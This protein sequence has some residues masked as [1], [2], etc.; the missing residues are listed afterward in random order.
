M[1][2]IS[3]STF[4]IFNT[5]CLIVIFVKKVGSKFF[6]VAWIIQIKIHLFFKPRLIWN[7]KW[8]GTLTR[9]G[10]S[11]FKIYSCICICSSP[12]K[13]CINW[14]N[15][16]RNAKGLTLCLNYTGQINQGRQ[17]GTRVRRRLL[18]FESTQKRAAHISSW[19]LAP[20][21]RLSSV[22]LCR[23]LCYW[24]ILVI[25][26]WSIIIPWRFGSNYVNKALRLTKTHTKLE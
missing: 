4:I 10:A 12:M 21:R 23:K 16:I 17:K 19:I 2:Y 9:M 1:L 6:N 13:N 25:V 7:T 3:H 11:I 26:Y 24:N 20:V 22:V 18:L 15:R 14:R 5:R 8:T